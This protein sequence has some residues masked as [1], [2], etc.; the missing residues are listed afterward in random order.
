MNPIKLYIAP[1]P[2][3][4]C[5]AQSWRG[6]V[7]EKNDKQIWSTRSW[8]QLYRTE[9]QHTQKDNKKR[10]KASPRKQRHRHFRSFFHGTCSS[11]LVFF[12]PWW[13]IPL[14]PTKHFDTCNG[15]F[16]NYGCYYLCSLF[17]FF[18][19]WSGSRFKCEKRSF[20]Y[21]FFKFE[22]EVVV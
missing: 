17:S 11:S 2:L 9:Q 7:S 4:Y 16:R 19:F 22:L 8:Y 14:H 1:S 21:D 18:L 10:I 13:L 20:H 12:C 5:M 3:L 6:S 15:I